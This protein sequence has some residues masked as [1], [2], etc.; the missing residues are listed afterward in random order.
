MN[1]GVFIVNISYKVI[2][3]CQFCIILYPSNCVDEGTIVSPWNLSISIMTCRSQVSNCQARY[4]DKLQIIRPRLELTRKSFCFSGAKSWNDLPKNIREISHM[5]IFKKHLKAY[6][7]TQTQR[8]TLV[9]S[10]KGRYTINF[11]IT[12]FY[13]LFIVSSFIVS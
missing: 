2:F 8:Q 1:Q 13:T 7:Q 10:A 12:L 5:P 6:L 9:R 4:S 3:K 11:L